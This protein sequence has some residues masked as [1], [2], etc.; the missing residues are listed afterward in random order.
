MWPACTPIASAL[1]C[2]RRVPDAITDEG[3]A[4][5]RQRIGIARPHTNPPHYL[6]PNEDAF[7]HVAEAYG[8]DNPLWCD[9]E[10]GN[11][12]RWGSAIAPPHLVGGD[13]LIGENEV[14]DLDPDTKTLMKGDPLRGVHAY[15]AGSFREWWRPLFPGTR[16]TRRNAL[17]GV[18]DKASEFAQRAI[19]EWTAEVFA[20]RDGEPLSAQYRLMIRTERDKA[21]AAGKYEGTELRAYTDDEIVAIDAVYADERTRRRGKEPRLF[22][23]VDE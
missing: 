5:L 2:G 20:E 23:D 6:R 19:H 17:V 11:T 18:H 12:T 7:R 4:R 22:E 1:R 8:D 15:Y 13:T 14:T 10:Y 21:E 9:A 16:V 3:V